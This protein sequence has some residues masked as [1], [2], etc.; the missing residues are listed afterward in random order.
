MRRVFLFPVM[1]YVLRL[2]EKE[3]LSKIPPSGETGF[4]TSP[5]MKSITI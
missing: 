2:P 1:A 5:Y 3:P 4:S